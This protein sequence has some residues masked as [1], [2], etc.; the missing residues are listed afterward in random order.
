M[1]KVLFSGQLKTREINFTEYF[2]IFSVG[3][4]WVEWNIRFQRILK[5]LQQHDCDIICL[6]E[7]QGKSQICL[8]LS[9]LFVYISTFADD[10]YVSQ[11][12][13][14]LN[15]LGYDSVF[16]KRTGDKKDGCAIFY[17]REKVKNE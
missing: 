16:K 15:E 5:E 2:W 10:H 4:D 14:A 12:N 17:K 1:I 11:I 6:Q 7:V 8:H 13:P 3:I 9:Q